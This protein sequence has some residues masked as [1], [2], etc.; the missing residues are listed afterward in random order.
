MRAGHHAILPGLL[1][2]AHRREAGGANSLH[3]FTGESFGV[4][5]I[6]PSQENRLIPV[7]FL[8]HNQNVLS[9][10]TYKDIW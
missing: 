4:C 1:R 2:L 5:G 7:A 10:I 8:V 6:R 9:G 3:G